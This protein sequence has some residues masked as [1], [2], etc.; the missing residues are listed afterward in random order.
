M[1]LTHKTAVEDMLESSDEKHLCC[2]CIHAKNLSDDDMV[3]TTMDPTSCNIVF[4]Q[5]EGG[6]APEREDNG[7]GYW[8]TKCQHYEYDKDWNR[9]NYHDYIKSDKWKTKRLECLKRDNYQCQKCGTAIN[10]VIHHS[11]Y[12]RLGNEDMGDLVTLCKDCHKKVHENDLRNRELENAVI[13][14]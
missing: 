11:T 14:Q 3:M 5:Y 4:E 12:D 10:L 9:V 8:V 13:R 7:S 6:Y 1:E 2:T